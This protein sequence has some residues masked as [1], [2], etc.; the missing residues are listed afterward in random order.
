[1]AKL[2][3][4]EIW[5]RIN[6]RQPGNGVGF[7]EIRLHSTADERPPRFQRG[8]DVRH[9]SCLLIVFQWRSVADGIIDTTKSSVFHK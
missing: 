2:A 4:V 7:G 3:Q 5:M 9:V 8:G 1:M 6:V